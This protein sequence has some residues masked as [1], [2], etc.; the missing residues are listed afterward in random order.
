VRRRKL[1]DAD[2]KTLM[3]EILRCSLGGGRPPVNQSVLRKILRRNLQRRDVSVEGIE[4]VSLL[5]QQRTA[6]QVVPSIRGT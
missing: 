1:L 6:P 4:T 5:W 3:N 2:I